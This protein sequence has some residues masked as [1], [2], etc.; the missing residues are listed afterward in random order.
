MF[1]VLL[2][3]RSV[4]PTFCLQKVVSGPSREL[5]MVG[6]FS[7]AKAQPT[8]D[9]LNVEG[10]WLWSLLK[11]TAGGGGLTRVLVLHGLSTCPTVFTSMTYFIHII[12][13]AL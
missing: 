3:L 13:L 6:T 5:Q 8:V 12:C 4:C 1:T 9:L 11:S 7:D 2:K 10:I